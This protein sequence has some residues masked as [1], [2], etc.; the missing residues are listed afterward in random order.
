MNSTN[1]HPTAIISKE[2]QIASNV[3]IGPYCIIKGNVKIDEGTILDEHVVIGTEVGVVEIG[4]N[5]HIY[6]GAVLGG[7]PQDKKYK[8]EQTRLLIGDTNHI[9]E[10]V[11]L[12]LGTP[13]GG[14][15]TT[16]GNGNLIMSYAHLGHDCFLGDNNVIANSCQFAGH[17]HV[18]SNVTV[19]GLCAI[20]QFVKIGSYAFIAGF[21]PINKDILPYCIAQGNYAVARATNKIGL[22]RAGFT[23]DAIDKINKAIRLISK[24][25][26]N[27]EIR[28]EKV[29]AECG[30][31]KEIDYIIEFARSS[32]R[33]LAI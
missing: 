27:I 29:L 11:T 14:G 2:A 20:N 19:G 12:S 6:A 28:L 24:G 7:V 10:F 8:N 18:E 31:S 25:T 13:N 1:I 23:E 33:G 3:Q 21:C 22:E 5:N 15:T 16:V 4:K 9:R 30:R 17:V 32:K 26:E